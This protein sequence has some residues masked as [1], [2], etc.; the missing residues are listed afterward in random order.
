MTEKQ[1]DRWYCLDIKGV[2]TL[3]ANEKDAK[4]TAKEADM[5]YPKNG[6]HKAVQLVEKG[7]IE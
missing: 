4:Q 6:P 7:K 3:C 2:A 5:D 1:E